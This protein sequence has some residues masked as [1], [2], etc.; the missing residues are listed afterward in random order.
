MKYTFVN[1][2][3]LVLPLSVMIV[4]EDFS[5]IA[6]NSVNFECVVKGGHPKP[7]IIWLKEDFEL[8]ESLQYV[9]YFMSRTYLNEM[10]LKD[11]GDETIVSTIFLTLN[12]KDHE[13]E[14]ACRA[15]VEGLEGYLEDRI[16]LSIQ[17]KC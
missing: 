8:A 16:K 1:G 2:F 9:R 11:S 17:C 10:F 12:R 3:S 13:K 7:R 14:L 6:G 5:L 15:V 4:K